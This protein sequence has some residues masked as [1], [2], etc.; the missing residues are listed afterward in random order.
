MQYRPFGNTGIQVSALGFG[1]MR[2]PA[3][4]DKKVDLEQAVP[5]LR[6]GI[7]LGITYIDSAYVYI[8]GTSEVAVGQAIK[9]YN[10]EKLYLATKIP[11]HSPEDSD[12]ATWRAKLETCL[13][14]FDTPYIDFI[15]FHGL[16]WA[17]FEQVVSKPGM[18]LEA[19]RKAQAEGLVRHI[20][21]SSHDDVNNIIKLIDTAEFASM[22]VQYNYLDRHNEPAIEHAGRNGMGVAIMGPVAGGRLAIPGGVIVDNEGMLEV[23]TPELALRFVL[24]NPNVS[25]ALSGMNE[26]AQIEE[27]CASASRVGTMEDSEQEAVQ[28]LLEKNQK[29]ADL[30][31]TGCAYCMPCPNDVNIPENFR[32]MNWYRVWGLEEQAKAAYARLSSEGTWGPWAGQI[33]G[34]NAEACLQCG[35][36]EPKCPQNIHI[37][38]QLV[39]V[40]ET[41]GK[42]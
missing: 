5:M 22:L 11:V 40:A 25:V 39:E 37:I 24:N 8:D 14:R 30:Y 27:N 16:R 42:K 26:M 12:G 28:R 15:H 9:G 33:K 7:D 18:A 31:C 23:K 4:E 41:L 32:Y 19:A 38:D 13:K 21:F 10:R 3:R 6:R 34:L 36:C 29:L 17:E 1:A 35:E 2:L 20:S